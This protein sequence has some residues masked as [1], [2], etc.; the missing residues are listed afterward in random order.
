V[1][2][3]GRGTAGSGWATTHK[4]VLLCCVAVACCCLKFIPSLGVFFRE[5]ECVGNEKNC[6]LQRVKVGM[7]PCC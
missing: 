5:E 2:L 3:V 6:C 1:P 4:E 7:E